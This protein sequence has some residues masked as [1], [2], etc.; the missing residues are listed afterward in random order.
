M[1]KISL[2]TTEYI[3]SLHSVKVTNFLTF[4]GSMFNV[5]LVRFAEQIYFFCRI[6]LFCMNDMFCMNRICLYL[7]NN[8][9]K[10]EEDEIKEAN[11]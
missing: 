7:L 11:L 8:F 10:I 9:I 6:C 2:V 1:Y 3:M 5:Y 4:K